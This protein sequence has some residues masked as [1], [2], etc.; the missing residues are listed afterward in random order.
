MIE[1]HVG[2][3][4][5]D[6]VPWLG[7]IIATALESTTPGQAQAFL[8]GLIGNIVGHID[9]EFFEDMKEASKKP[10][11][12]EGCECHLVHQSCFEELEKLRKEWNRVTKERGENPDEKGFSE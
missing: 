1:I 2:G 8:G 10:C 6:K 9:D 7:P 5:P 4:P 3:L 12:I 11:G